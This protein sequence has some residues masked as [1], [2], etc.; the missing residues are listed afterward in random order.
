MDRAVPS[1]GYKNSSIKPRNEKTQKNAK[2]KHSFLKDLGIIS[3]S[4]QSHCA[5]DFVCSIDIFFS[6]DQAKE[7]NT[8]AFYKGKCLPKEIIEGPNCSSLLKKTV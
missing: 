1:M 3:T 5:D 4:D 7:K 2:Y 8:V 6:L